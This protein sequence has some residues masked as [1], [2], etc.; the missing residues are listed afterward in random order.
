MKQRPAIGVW[1]VAML[2]FTISV[3]AQGKGFLYHYYPGFACAVTVTLLMTALPSARAGWLD[4][5]RRTS[6]GAAL[7]AMCAASVTVTA[8]RAFGI[9]GRTS[10]LGREVS[11]LLAGVPPGTTIAM[12]S[13]RL[14]DGF[15]IALEQNYRLVGRFPHLWFMYPYDSAAVRLPEGIRPYH[16][17]VL[18][19]LERS[20]RQQVAEDFADARPSLLAIRNMGGTQGT[21]RYLCDDRVFRQAARR[22]HLVRR[23]GAM[24][25]YQRDT[26][27]HSEGACGS[28]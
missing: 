21:Q 19:P 5:L 23:V 4:A 22:Y 25:L 2:G 7:I 6:A 17:S 26:T 20:L 28:L 3:M 16:D 15:P 18:T 13:S 1:L 12:E 8:W 27:M 11:Q 24:Q 9:A 10:P 14:G